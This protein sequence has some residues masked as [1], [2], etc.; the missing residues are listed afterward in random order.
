VPVQEA[1]LRSLRQLG[2][3]VAGAEQNPADD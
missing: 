2:N 3:L 1:A